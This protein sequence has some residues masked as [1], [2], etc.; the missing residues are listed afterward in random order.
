MR[1]AQMTSTCTEVLCLVVA[2]W[3]SGSV[4]VGSILLCKWRRVWRS[5]DK[6]TRTTNN[7]KQQQQ[8]RHGLI[9]DDGDDDG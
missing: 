6:Q 2:V 1:I 7:N 5:N 9:D 8:Q 3:Q 4:I